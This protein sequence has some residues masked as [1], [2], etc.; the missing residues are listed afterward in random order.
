MVKERMKS[1]EERSGRVPFGFREVP[2]SEKQDLV[3]AVF[4]TVAARYDRMNDLMSGGFHRLWKEA[5][6]DWLAPPRAGKRVYRVLDLAGGTG[7]VAFRIA[8]RSERAEITVADINPSMLEVGRQRAADRRLD[9]RVAFKEG[10]AEALP[11]DA[12]S[13]DAVTIAFGIRNVTHLDKAIAEAHRVLK[14]GGRFL[15]LEFSTVDVAI[16]DRLYEA[17]SFNVIPAIGRMVVGEAEPYQY[18]VESIRRFPNQARFAAMLEAGGFERV[19]Y[20]N[21]SGG[22]V[23]LHSGWKL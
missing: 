21:L 1:G 14:P 10:N 15:V 5:L 4:H 17:Y 19:A 13:F 2:A 6:V 22:I 12:G 11:F 3:D 20:R 9:R 18:L 23:A 8:A 7:D 16:L